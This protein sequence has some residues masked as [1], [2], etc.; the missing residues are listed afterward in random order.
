MYLRF[1]VEQSIYN[2][3]NDSI[4]QINKGLWEDEFD[5]S[6]TPQLT[7]R[8]GASMVKYVYPAS[9]YRTCFIFRSPLHKDIDVNMLLSPLETNVWVWSGVMLIVFSIIM[10]VVLRFEYPENG[11]V[12]RYMNSVF[13]MLTVICQQG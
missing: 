1:Q 8:S 5:F 3:L 7:S 13:L 12:W 4:D 11:V 2:T 10:G 6:G 9:L